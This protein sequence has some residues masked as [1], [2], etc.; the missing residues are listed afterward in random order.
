M[1]CQSALCWAGACWLQHCRSWLDHLAAWAAC[2][3]G[4]VRLR[5]QVGLLWSSQQS[6]PWMYSI[7][8]VFS[9]IH[10][11]RHLVD[12]STLN[13]DPRC[14]LVALCHSM[15]LSTRFFV[16]RHPH[17]L[18]SLEFIIPDFVELVTH[19][20]P[21]SLERCAQELFWWSFDWVWVF[22]AMSQLATTSGEL[23]FNCD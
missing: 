11:T 3:T 9:I 14:L 6:H 22:C 15:D 21:S 1:A 17:Q 2:W 4:W 23:F 18:R 19:L 12:F 13:I 10:R 7:R 20:S 16:M 8:L 5:L